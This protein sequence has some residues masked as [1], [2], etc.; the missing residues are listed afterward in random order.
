MRKWVAR[1]DGTVRIEGRAEIDRKGGLG[2]YVRIVKNASEVFPSRLV[3]FGN[4]A[5]HDV[6][7]RVS[8]GDAIGFAVKESGKS[9]SEKVLWD[10]AI[11]YLPRGEQGQADHLQDRR[12][13]MEGP[14]LR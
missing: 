8:K 2:A 14:G 13:D 9:V 7:V 3:R 1:H 5:A 10:P 12:L 11:T 4:G 6:I